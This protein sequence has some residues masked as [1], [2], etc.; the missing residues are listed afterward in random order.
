MESGVAVTNG[1]PAEVLLVSACRCSPRLELPPAHRLLRAPCPAAIHTFHGAYDDDQISSFS[2]RGARP[3]PVLAR[4]TARR[5]L[6][7][8][9]P[10][11]R[12]DL[13]WTQMPNPVWTDARA[14]SSL[15]VDVECF[16]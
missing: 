14:S 9:A 8:E 2:V 6:S 16:A 3:T 1:R 13:R 10:Q 11:R 15:H 12:A 5:P 4:C 7:E